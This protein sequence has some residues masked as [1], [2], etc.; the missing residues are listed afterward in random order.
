MGFSKGL[1]FSK[2]NVKAMRNR[3]KQGK[4]LK[5][6]YKRSD[7]GTKSTI[8]EES[9]TRDTISVSQKEIIANCFLKDNNWDYEYH[10]S[11]L[12]DSNLPI[13]KYNT[14]LTHRRSFHYIEQ[15]D[16][17]SK[18]AEQWA[19]KTEKIIHYRDLLETI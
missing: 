18:V 10:M 15:L 9:T 11:R 2:M 19:H 16:N 1:D 14:W 12:T 3:F 13:I 8:K 6:I 7:T 5:V 17:P 4:S